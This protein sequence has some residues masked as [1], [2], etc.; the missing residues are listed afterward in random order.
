MVGISTPPQPE[1]RLGAQAGMTYR[2]KP[3]PFVT[4]ADGG[5]N[6]RVPAQVGGAFVVWSPPQP[7]DVE[8]GSRSRAGQSAAE[9]GGAKRWPERDRGP[10]FHPLA[11]K[12]APH[13]TAKE[14]ISGAGP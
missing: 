13:P 2:P 6:L 8:R 9:G 7:A 14:V 11:R 10:L 12:G 4:W 1:G 3:I 5:N